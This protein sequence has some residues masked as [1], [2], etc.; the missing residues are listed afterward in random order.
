[1][2]IYLDTANINEIREA[3]SWGILDG[4]TTNP[5]LLAKEKRP[6][7]EVINEIVKLV[8]GP[9][10]VE[11]TSNTPEKMIQEGKDLAS[12]HRNIVI[13]VPITP[14]GLKVTKSLSSMGIR[15][16]Q[17]L[18]FTPSQAILAAKAGA[19]CVSPFLGRLDDISESG[20]DLIRK[21]VVIF[22]N[23]QF[24]TLIL[25]ASIRTPPHVVECALAG[26]DIVTMPFNV[27]EKLV[28]HPLTDRGIEL[29]AKDWEKLQNE[30]KGRM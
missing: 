20:I 9:I 29:F 15:V 21:M 1:M 25:A 14:D 12:I 23:Y 6:M 2:K 8:D 4:V 16:N 26:A 28:H 18:I 7:R 3:A 19:W 22:R 17:T 27:L 5:T 13:K 10:S 24:K 11:V 30:L